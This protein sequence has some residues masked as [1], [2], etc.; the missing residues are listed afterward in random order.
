MIT[1]LIVDDE[2]KARKVLQNQLSAAFND[3]KVVATAGSVAE[4]YAAIIKHDPQL[5]LLDIEMPYGNGFDLLQKF[6]KVNFDVIFTTAYGHYAIKAI[7]ASALDYLMKPIDAEELAM[8]ID[9]IRKKN[10]QAIDQKIK[11]LLS[12][13]NNAQPQKIGITDS[14]GVTFALVNEIVTCK[15]HNNQTYFQLVSG[16]ELPSIKTLKEYETLLSPHGFIRVHHSTIINLNHVKKYIK[17]EG[18]TV[19]MEGGATVEI[20]R[21]KKAEFLKQLAQK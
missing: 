7:K 4:A 19:V 15:A 16:K 2:E 18:G 12:N 21:R 13:L 6:D 17:G 11:A 20:S 14:H 1:T 8:A 3:V 9:K 5:V 10:E